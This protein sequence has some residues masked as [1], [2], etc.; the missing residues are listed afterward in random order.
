M[1]AILLLSAL[2]LGLS[3]C[4]ETAPVASDSPSSTV[5]LAPRI[6]RTAAVP[7]PLF[8]G[9]DRVGVEVYDAGSGALLK[10]VSTDF[11]LHAIDVVG[12]PADARVRVD[13]YG[14]D[15]SGSIVWYGVSSPISASAASAGVGVNLDIS[16]APYQADPTPY[17]GEWV[18][19]NPTGMLEGT[20]SGSWTTVARFGDDG[21]FHWENFFVNPSGDVL[22]RYVSEGRYVQIGSRLS[23]A[24]SETWICGAATTYPSGTCNSDASLSSGSVDPWEADFTKGSSG[25]VVMIGT[26]E[27]PFGTPATSE[28]LYPVTGMWNHSHDGTI[29]PVAG[30][31]LEGTWAT[32]VRFAADGS[33]IWVQMFS[34][35]R[36]GRVAKHYVEIGAYEKSGTSILFTPSEASSCDAGL[37][38]LTVSCAELSDG[39]AT[40]PDAPSTWGY[41]GNIGTMVLTSPGG[42][43]WEF[44][45]QPTALGGAP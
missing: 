24:P 32:S 39:T 45:K 6:V 10:S 38:Y 12:I 14:Y 26:A 9:T 31:N 29:T 40:T 19:I 3:A 17:L 4:Q 7:V 36:T 13:V 8:D 41:A 35:G 43:P 5:T 11:D 44:T 23:L 25:L 27:F 42:N 20:H 2:F 22:S 1:R 33:Y 18:Y 30:V 34:V 16:I 21:Q 15:P 37:E 28:G